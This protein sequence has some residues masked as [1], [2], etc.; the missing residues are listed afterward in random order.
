MSVGMVVWEWCCTTIPTLFGLPTA[1]STSSST[2]LYTWSL[3]ANNYLYYI[4]YNSIPIHMRTVNWNRV[5]S[6]DVSYYPGWLIRE[7]KR[8]ESL[9][10]EP[11]SLA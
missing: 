11:R 8:Q 2:H 3:F 10:I 7:E 9:E 5:I 4:L 1:I 6:K